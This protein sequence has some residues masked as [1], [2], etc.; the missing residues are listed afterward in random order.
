M[1]LY[2]GPAIRSHLHAT[3]LKDAWR[4]SCQTIEVRRVTESQNIAACHAW[5]LSPRLKSDLRRN[6]F[7]FTKE[8]A[9][10]TISGSGLIRCFGNFLFTIFCCH[11]FILSEFQMLLV[12]ELTILS[13]STC[14]DLLC[15]C[16]VCVNLS[17]LMARSSLPIP[18]TVK[19]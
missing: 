19:C 15:V 5:F 4:R 12:Q 11:I 17:N 10:L 16:R 7:A 3:L 6:A 2:T 1:E 18:V 8:S 9:A 14:R 13:C